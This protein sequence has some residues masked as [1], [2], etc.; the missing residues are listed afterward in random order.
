MMATFSHFHW[1]F[2]T[3]IN[4]SN[5][6]T[7]LIITSIFFFRTTHK[8]TQHISTLTAIKP[9]TN[10]P[11]RRPGCYEIFEMY[12][13][14]GQDWY[15]KFKKV[16]I[17]GPGLF[18]KNGKKSTQCQDQAGMKTLKS[19]SNIP[20]PCPYNIP[21]PCRYVPKSIPDQQS[22]IVIKNK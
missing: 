13:I 9:F 7:H 8:P 1:S 18:Q 14:T 15:E 2:K 3:F 16:P 5:L 6:I 20:R 22:W 4:L 10:H 11:I 12:S 21:G 19:A 17:P